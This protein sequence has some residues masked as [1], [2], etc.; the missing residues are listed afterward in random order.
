MP[1]RRF[2]FRLLALVV[3]VSALS[4]AGAIRGGA[5][6]SPSPPQRLVAALPPATP[7]SPTGRYSNG[8]LLPNGRLVKPAGSVLNL[9]DFP[10]AAA[11]SPDSTLAV[12]SNSGQGEG[13]NPDQGNETL[14]VVD[15]VHRRVVQTIADHEAGQ[16]TFYSSGVA[17]SPSGRHVY[18]TGGG[19]DEVY[20]YSV[21]AGHLSLVH[22]WR[23]T[24]K[25][26]PVE[27]DAG[28]VYGYSRGV[29]VS[30][31]GSRLYVANEQGGSVAAVSTTDGSIA[32]ETQL[33]GTAM[34]GPYP[35]AVAVAP[36]GSA[37]YV[38]SQGRNVVTKL[39]PT[40]GAVIGMTSVGDHPVAIALDRS[41]TLAFVANA[42][43][44]SVSILDLRSPV[45][46]T[47][48]QLSTHLF[49]GEASGSA[50][51]AVAVDDA[52]K[53]VY[54]ANAGDDAVAV[55]GMS[56]SKAPAAW[57]PS[58]L[59]VLGFVPGAWYPSAVALVPSDHSVL[60][61]SAKGYGGV[62]VTRHTQYDGNDMVGLLSRVVA[63]TLDSVTK[64]RQQAIDRLWFGAQA[65]ASRPADSPIPNAQHEG[66]SPIK[67][68]VLV[69]RENRTFDQVFGD[70]RSLG[71]T[72]ADV[73]PS[74]L[75]FGRTDAKGKTVTPNAHAIAAQFGLSDNFYS[76]GEASIQGHHWTAEGTSTDYTEKSWVHYYSA[77][78]HPYDPVFPIVY[79]RCGAIFQRLAAAGVDFRNFGELVGLQTS[80]APAPAGP[81]A[82]CT[83]SGGAY[84]GTSVA[85][86]DA[87]YPDN[88][89]LTS[90]KDTDR[91][92]EFERYYE[93]LVEADRVPAFSYVLMGN[94]HTEGTTPAASRRRPSSRSTT[95][96][97]AGSSTT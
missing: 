75:E 6:R 49:P 61:V 42:N 33:D 74:F 3:T 65:N 92:A 9:G 86:H 70:L 12:V 87:A 24:H 54:V 46:T 22:R 45:P 19:N 14:Q 95:W 16:P 2:A 51:D 7:Y 72:D 58:A 41:G 60:T 62:P 17:F 40:T 56:L 80:Q 82:Q 64:G 76:D 8:A 35:G 13:S 38:T 59:R 1:R 20:D 77:R 81:D 90:I 69:V 93:P 83:V 68:V 97:S 78:N 32:W 27:G 23:T 48:A 25:Q 50:P 5:G 85:S 89:T 10:V 73:Q 71:R 88:L 91:L 4:A 44:D 29:A 47:V 34:G 96:R 36:D 94:D 53:V 63:P 31:A 18:V 52:R 30:P 67:H 11:V 43:D 66:Q 28:D 15:L 55:V 57:N 39:Q 84:D 21:A 26:G 37:V 79:P